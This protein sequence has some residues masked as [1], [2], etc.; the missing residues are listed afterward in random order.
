MAAAGSPVPCCTGRSA[1]GLAGTGLIAIGPLGVAGTT[2][3][4][5]V[6]TGVIGIGLLASV[7]AAVVCGHFG[8]GCS[9][10]AC[11]ANVDVTV[12]GNKLSIQSFQTCASTTTT[13]ATGVCTYCAA[14]TGVLTLNGNNV[15][16]PT[17]CNASLIDIPA[18]LS[19]TFNKQSCAAGSLTATGLFINILNG[20]ETLY[21]SQ[22]TVG[23]S[24]CTNCAACPSCT[25]CAQCVATAP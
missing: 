24:T 11:V 16:I 9:A 3:E 15:P 7:S 12:A 19:V 18:V 20:L 1:F 5:A 10:R 8:S 25:N 2:Q 17:G 13:A 14:A 4:C 23:C 22:A 6:N 21:V